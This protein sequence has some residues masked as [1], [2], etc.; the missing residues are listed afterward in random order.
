MAV[1][2]AEPQAV[3]I[4]GASGDLARRK[5]LPAFFHLYVE[6]LLPRGFAIVGYARS[7]LTDEEFRDRAREAI[8]EFGRCD[9]SGEEWAGFAGIL[10]YLPGEFDSE[11]STEHLRERLEEIDHEPG[12][13]G[14]RFYYW[15]TPPEV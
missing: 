1:K 5:L 15:A 13:D 7:Q 14:G 12:R 2:P 3:V 11:R 8:R 4:F 10:S 9:P 6:G